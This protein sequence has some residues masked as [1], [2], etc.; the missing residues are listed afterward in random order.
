[1]ITAVKTQPNGLGVLRSDVRTTTETPYRSLTELL[2]CDSVISTAVKKFQSFY[3][4]TPP[5]LPW[6]W[7]PPLSTNGARKENSRPSNLEHAAPD[8]D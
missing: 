4:L 7:V 1:V 8:F 6:E 3:R 5:S 2:Q